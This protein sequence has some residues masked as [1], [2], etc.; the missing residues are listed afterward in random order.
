MSAKNEKIAAK[1]EKIAAK[2]EKIAAERGNIAAEIATEVLRGNRAKKGDFVP[3][4]L[5]ID[6]H[7][8]RNCY[9][10]TSFCAPRCS[11]RCRR[12]SYVQNNA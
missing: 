10:L 11:F 2:N 6:M 7:A 4:R 3:S 1:N 9:F 8:E 12:A 5:H